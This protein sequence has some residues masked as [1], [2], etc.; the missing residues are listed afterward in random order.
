[1]IP[2]PEILKHYPNAISAPRAIF[3]LLVHIRTQVNLPPDQIVFA[4]SICGDDLNE[5][6]YP[7]LAHEMIGPFRLGGLNGYPFTGLTGIGALA[8]HVPDGG[9]IAIFYGPHIGIS[10]KGDVGSISRPGQAGL[11]ACCG[12]AKKGVAELT[13]PTKS[14]PAG[15]DDQMEKIKEIFKAKKSTILKAKFPIKAATDVMFAATDK[16]LMELLKAEKPKAT[17]FLLGGVLINAD[18]PFG[19]FFDRRKFGKFEN[20]KYTPI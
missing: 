11:N 3:D 2:Y 13:K 20:G 5:E 7:Q 14:A 19:S 4:D 8:S 10:E 17:V 9:A 6:Q 12:A 16:Q 18:Y 15:T 1:M